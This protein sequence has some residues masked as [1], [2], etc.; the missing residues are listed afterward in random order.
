MIRGHSLLGEKEV[1]KPVIK[2]DYNKKG[3]LIDLKDQMLQMYLIERKRMHK[4]Y[5]KLIK[6]LLN[7]SVLNAPIAYRKNHDE[8]VEHLFIEFC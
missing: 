7:A 6:R 4:W 5:H 1:R 2:T 3:G 8:A